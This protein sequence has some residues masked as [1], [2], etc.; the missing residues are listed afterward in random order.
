LREELPRLSPGTVYRNLELLVSEGHVR[1]VRS[2]GGASRYDGNT[3][4]HNHFI[5]EACGSIGDL[6]L[7]APA[8]LRRRLQRQYQL[9]A[10]RI[11]IDFYGLC[12]A[13]SEQRGAERPLHEFDT[14][15]TDFH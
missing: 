6:D 4:R 10:E 14:T 5:C 2:K 13:C 1:A 8:S 9:R 7:P 11:E 15:H 12:P 3:E